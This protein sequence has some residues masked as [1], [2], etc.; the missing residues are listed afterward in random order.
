MTNYPTIRP[1][2]PT[3][4]DAVLAI[5]AASPQAPRWPPTAWAPYL[6]PVDPNATLLRAAFIA[7]D[8]PGVLGFACATLLLDGQENRAELDSMAVHPA[9]RRRGLGSNL[10]RAV[11]SW[12]AAQGAHSL[13]LEVRVSNTAAIALY[14]RFGLRP[15]GRRPRYYADP[16]EDALLLATPVT[17]DSILP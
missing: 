15:E 2:R 12:S 6:A 5:A 9:A 13:T 1:M 17:I 8:G 14:Q 16:E 10:L 11:V 7:V 3:D 4:L